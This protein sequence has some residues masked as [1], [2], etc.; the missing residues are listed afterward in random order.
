MTH[1]RRPFS[2][3]VGLTETSCSGQLS[4]PCFYQLVRAKLDEQSREASA[5]VNLLDVL[6]IRR[7]SKTMAICRSASI[8]PGASNPV[9]SRLVH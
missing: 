7:K 8:G 5:T 1:P 4:S 3:S 2:R 6:A 9:E